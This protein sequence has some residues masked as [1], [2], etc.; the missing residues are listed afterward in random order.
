MSISGAFTH[1]WNIRLRDLAPILYVCG[2]HLSIRFHFD[3]DH[4]AWQ[5]H[6]I[7]ANLCTATLCIG[8]AAI[9]IEWG[10][11]FVPYG[12]RNT[13][14]WVCKALLAANVLA[15]VAYI[16]VENMSCV[17]HRKIWDRTILEGYCIDAKTFQIPGCLV[18]PIIILVILILPHRAIWS[19]QMSTKNKIG[20][21]FI[22]L[23]GL[24]YGV[25]T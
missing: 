21:S 12:T 22:F 20:I 9:L 19:L 18:N 13:F 8:K 14:Y 7:G 15:H 5:I 2:R 6:H 16:V 10:R 11:I 4:L 23:V 25:V 24:L 3:T 17:P 1:Q